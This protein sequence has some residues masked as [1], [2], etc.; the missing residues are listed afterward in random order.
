MSFKCGLI[1]IQ[2]EKTTQGT[3]RNSEFK[4]NWNSTFSSSPKNTSTAQAG[5]LSAALSS[6]SLNTI[7][8]I[9]PLCNETQCSWGLSTVSY[10]E[11]GSP[12]NKTAQSS[13]SRQ[14]R[15]LKRRQ[16]SPADRA[17]HLIVDGMILVYDYGLLSRSLQNMKTEFCFI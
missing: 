8:I 14:P 12:T 1:I 5:V 2:S 4:G 13:S 11:T 16:S 3:P 17:K 10:N 15:N 9:F 7:D 6:I